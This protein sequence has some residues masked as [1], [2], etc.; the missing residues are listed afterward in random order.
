MDSD[1]V[2]KFDRM[3][4]PKRAPPEILSVISRAYVAH[5]MGHNYL[6]VL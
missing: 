4:S 1:E 6:H 5:K 2:L 3:P